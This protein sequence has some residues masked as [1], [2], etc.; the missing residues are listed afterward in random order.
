MPR[1]ENPMIRTTLKR[2]GLRWRWTIS[3]GGVEV[4]DVCFLKSRAAA[5]QA[6]LLREMVNV[7][8]PVK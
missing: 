2:D 8:R 1:N 7:R 4:E 3:A 5:Q 6:G